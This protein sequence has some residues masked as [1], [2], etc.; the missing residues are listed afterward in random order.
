M[1]KQEE[2]D[3]RNIWKSNVLMSRLK[4]H[5]A[6]D[7]T[8]I[9]KMRCSKSSAEQKSFWEFQY[10]S[11]FHT[12]TYIHFPLLRHCPFP[13]SPCSS[14][15][16]WYTAMLAHFHKSVCLKERS[17]GLRKEEEGVRK[18][19]QWRKGTQKIFLA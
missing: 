3:L 8:G 14:I 9:R 16:L 15:C 17:L 4:W 2:E 13:P 1:Q 10:F 5:H 18:L 12:E 6:K 19:G 11:P 7:C